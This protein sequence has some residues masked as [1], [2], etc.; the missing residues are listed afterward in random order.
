MKRV[1]VTGS[2]GLIGSEAVAFFDQRGWAVHGID[3]NMRR[4]LFGPDGIRRG[5]SSDL[6][7]RPGISPRMI[8]T[9]AIVRRSSASSSVVD[10]SAKERPFDDFDINAVGTLTLLEAARRHCP[11]TP[12]IFMS[13]N[14]VYGDAPNAKRLVELSTRW[15]YAEPED[16]NGIAEDCPV[17]ASL[18]SLF[19]VSKRSEERRVGKE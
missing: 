4:D 5:I 17:D 1:L 16:Y 3:N 2:S 13:T 8:W 19:G 7:K 9:F 6:E 12:F 15:D 11:E 14:Q 18:H 10:L